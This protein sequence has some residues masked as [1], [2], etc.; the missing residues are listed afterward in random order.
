[1]AESYPLALIT[2]GDLAD[3][4]RKIAVSGLENRFYHIEILSDKTTE[5][6]ASLFK[7]MDVDPAHLLMVG[8]SIR[9]DILPV[10]ALGGWAVYVP[11]PS[12]WSHEMM[13]EVPSEDA[14]RFFELPHLGD[15]PGLVKHIENGR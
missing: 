13:G 2:K 10:L 11:Y 4:E 3:Q 6:Y 12:T 5:T 9:S 15:L 14:A 1:M 7:R 8:N